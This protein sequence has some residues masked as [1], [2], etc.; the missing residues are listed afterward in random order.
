MGV[1]RVF[2]ERF[3]SDVERVGVDGQPYAERL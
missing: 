1:L 2:V 3:A